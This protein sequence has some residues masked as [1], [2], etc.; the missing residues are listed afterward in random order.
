MSTRAPGVSCPHPGLSPPAGQAETGHSPAVRDAV[1]QSPHHLPDGPQV[2]S[3]CIRQKYPEMDGGIPPPLRPSSTA[4]GP[5]SLGPRAAWPATCK[6]A[7]GASQARGVRA[8]LRGVSLEQLARWSL[9]AGGRK[10][11]GHLGREGG[12]PRSRGDNGTHGRK[13]MGQGRSPAPRAN[14]GSAQCRE[15]RAGPGPRGRRLPDGRH[16]GLTRAL[17]ACVPLGP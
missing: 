12:T 9:Q 11:P 3:R 14:T 13:A 16:L 17:G 4:C 6:D 1:G 2:V 8:L 7:R 5:V 10:L 15:A